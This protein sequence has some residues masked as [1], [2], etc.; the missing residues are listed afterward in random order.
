[1]AGQIVGLVKEEKPTEAILGDLI[2]QAEQ[3]LL[4]REL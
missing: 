4:Q 3:A 1:M 2:Q